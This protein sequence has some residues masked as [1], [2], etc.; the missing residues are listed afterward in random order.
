MLGVYMQRSWIVLF[1]CSF[2]LLPLY[3]YAI[4]ILKLMGQPDKVAEQSGMLALWFI[5]MH[6]SFVFQCSLQRFLQ[7][8]LKTAVLAWASLAALVVHVTISWLFVYQFKLGL[9]GTAVALDV[10]WWVFVLGLLGYTV[11]GGCPQTWTGFS[12]QA[13]SGLWEFFKLSTAPG[14]MLCMAING[15]KMMIPLSFFAAA[16]VRVANEL[17]ARNGKGAK[18]ATKVVVLVGVDL[19]AQRTMV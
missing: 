19:R 6:F 13:F 12:M 18:F 3:V 11:W 14:V 2:L 1:L 5:P 10:S 8:Q 9:V 15:W 4:P 7:S 17:R 16:G